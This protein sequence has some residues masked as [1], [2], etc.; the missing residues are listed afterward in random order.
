[1]DETYDIMRT[2]IYKDYLYVR[3][4]MWHLPYV[5]TIRSMENHPIIAL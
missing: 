2:V 3:N 5:Q 4:Y 1:M